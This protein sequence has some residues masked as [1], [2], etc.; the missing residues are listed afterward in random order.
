MNAISEDESPKIL[1]ASIPIVKGGTGISNTYIE[2][3]L[4]AFSPN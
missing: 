4:T 1:Y 2:N 3:I